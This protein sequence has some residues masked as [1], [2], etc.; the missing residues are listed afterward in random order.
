MTESNA[1]GTP[2]IAYD[3][4]GLRDSVKNGVNRVL[5]EE[6]TPAAMA[7]SA[8]DL[9]G[10]DARLHRMSNSALDYSRQFNWDNTASYFL[11]EIEALK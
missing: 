6:R 4:P 7:D 9:L 2:V 8:L 1:M 10:D 5:V 3:V 11:K